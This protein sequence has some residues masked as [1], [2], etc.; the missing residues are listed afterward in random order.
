[1]YSE[2]S[3]LQRNRQGREANGDG[4][5]PCSAMPGFKNGK[6][7]PITKRGARARASPVTRL[8][9]WLAPCWAY[10]PK[11]EPERWGNE[12]FTINSDETR[13]STQPYSA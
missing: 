11:K 12:T 10:E 9:G 13:P 3:T 4:S 6:Y 2:P 5:L 1:M 8:L 7:L